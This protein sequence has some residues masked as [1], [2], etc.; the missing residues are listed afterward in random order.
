[1]TIFIVITLQL[2]TTSNPKSLLSKP[3]RLVNIIFLRQPITELVTFKTAF[4]LHLAVAQLFFNLHV[5]DSLHEVLFSLD[6]T[7]SVELAE[8]IALHVSTS[9]SHLSIH[10]IHR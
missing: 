6:K 9:F 3:Y 8:N 2:Q 5:P 4:Q 7:C 1:M 10:S